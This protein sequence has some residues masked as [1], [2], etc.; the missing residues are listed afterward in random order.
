[1]NRKDHCQDGGLVTGPGCTCAGKVAYLHAR[2]L[3]D[4][5]GKLAKAPGG[6]LRSQLL[7]RS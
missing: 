4:V 2:N 3:P 5:S 7:P 6:N 1:M